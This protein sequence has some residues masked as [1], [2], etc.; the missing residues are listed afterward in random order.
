MRKWVLKLG[1]EFEKNT[2]FIFTFCVARIE[3]EY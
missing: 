2:I 1:W 3:Q